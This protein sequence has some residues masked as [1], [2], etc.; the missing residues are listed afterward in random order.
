MLLSF[1]L[2]GILLIMVVAF[3]AVT[4]TFIPKTVVKSAPQDIQEKVLTR[5]DYPKWKTVVGN[6]LAVLILLCNAAILILAGVDAVQE[7]MGFSMIFARY[8][9]LLVGYKIFDMVCFDWILL[10]KLNIFQRFFP[11]TAGCE[12]YK[13]F[14]FNVK[15]QVIKIIV[16]AFISLIVA[17]ILSVI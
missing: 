6:T 3:M 17:L 13:S 7:R 4:V 8:L 11:E 12:G 14:G 16:F 1:V 10:T 2:L 15:S 5:P 9:I